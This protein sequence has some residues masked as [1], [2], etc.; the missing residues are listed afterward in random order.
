MPILLFIGFS[1]LFVCLF[2]RLYYS[3][4]RK[5]PSNR[6]KPEWRSVSQYPVFEL[7]SSGL[8]ARLTFLEIFLA[9]P[10]YALHHPEA[11]PDRSTRQ[12]CGGKRGTGAWKQGTPETHRPGLPAVRIPGWLAA[13]KEGSLASP[14]PFSM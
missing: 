1:L 5:S 3:V 14:S 4:C 7:K 10:L 6:S 8:E 9:S 13:G 11:T 2:V 12:G